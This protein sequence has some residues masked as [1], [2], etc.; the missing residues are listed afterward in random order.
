MAG[1]ANKQQGS[2]CITCGRE[3]LSRGLC[4]SCYQSAIR[5]IKSGDATD[6]QL[7]ERGLILPKKK[8]QS[9]WSRKF[10]ATR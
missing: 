8:K 7:V 1:K 4:S 5:V 9:A 2:G 6:E 10:A 3:A